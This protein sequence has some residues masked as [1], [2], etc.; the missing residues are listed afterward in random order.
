VWYTLKGFHLAWFG[1]FLVYD[2]KSEFKAR[3]M[4]G[5]IEHGVIKASK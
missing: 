4:K 3:N 2:T 1:P 5:T